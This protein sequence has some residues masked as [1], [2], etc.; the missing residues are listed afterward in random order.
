[1]SIQIF[2]LTPKLTLLGA[3]EANALEPPNRPRF[4]GFVTVALLKNTPAGRAAGVSL[5]GL[6]RTSQRSPVGSELPK[7]V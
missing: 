7:E 4:H 6:R 2:L 5:G 3:I 1:M